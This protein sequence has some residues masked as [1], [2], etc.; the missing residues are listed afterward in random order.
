M[1]AGKRSWK[2][3]GNLIC[4]PVRH[5]RHLGHVSPLKKKKTTVA[6]ETGWP[7]AG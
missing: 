6:N 5:E 3:H 2:A 1:L 7:K 4:R